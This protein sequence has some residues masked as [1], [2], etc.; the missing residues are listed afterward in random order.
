MRPYRLRY[1][2]GKGTNFMKWQIRN[3][4]L[5]MVDYFDPNEFV[6]TCKNGKLN[7]NSRAAQNIHDGDNKTVCSWISYEDMGSVSETLRDFKS[8]EGGLTR[9][10]YN[11]RLKPYWMSF[12]FDEES[13]LDGFEG[14]VFIINKSL[15]V[16]T[17][18]LR[19]FVDKFWELKNRLLK[20]NI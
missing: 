15:Y 19:E 16:S 11:P 3:K 6:Y 13:N 2:L 20:L 10:S 9:I 8:V 12:D 5:D 7:N 17:N 14:D 1:H 4:E 18:E